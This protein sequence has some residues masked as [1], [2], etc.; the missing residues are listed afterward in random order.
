MEADADAA[1]VLKLKLSFT[2]LLM[3]LLMLLLLLRR[4]RMLSGGPLGLAS[5]G[6]ADPT[7]KDTLVIEGRRL[8][9]GVFAAAATELRS[10]GDMEER[11]PACCSELWLCEVCEV[12]EPNLTRFG[13]GLCC[14]LREL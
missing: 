8:A 14:G 12:R 3:A 11:R 13:R 4:F 2:A 9:G 7:W 1:D 6:G 10:L 5:L